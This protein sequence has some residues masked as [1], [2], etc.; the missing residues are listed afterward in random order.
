MASKTIKND[1]LEQTK[2]EVQNLYFIIAASVFFIC[3]ITFIAFKFFRNSNNEKREKE[4][5]QEEIDQKGNELKKI[6]LQVNESFEEIINLAKNNNP[7]FFKRFQEVYPEFINKL[8]EIKP[9]LQTS[10][11]TFCAYIFLN[12]STKDIANYTF[13]SPKTVQNRKHHIRKKL[14]IPS[15][16]DIYI[17]MKKILD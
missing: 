6:K 17:W 8:L 1:L 11:L 12:F 4:L 16:K 2:K 14:Q 5:K 13:T 7:Q 15:D 3:A 10:E 9:K